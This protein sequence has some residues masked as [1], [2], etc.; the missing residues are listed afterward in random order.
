MN[1]REQLRNILP[2]ILPDDPEEAI[3]GTELIR[4]VRL[5]LGDDY[6]D[7]TLRYHF[8]ILSYD[9]TSPIAK[10]D[11]GQGY[12]QRLS[13]PHLANGT[14]RF[15]F[16]GEVEGDVLQSRFLRLLTIYERLCL[17]RSHFPFRL[18]GRVDT[19][20]D[21]RGFWDI[22][23]LVTAEWDLETGADEI[24]RF[25]S[26]M[27][28]LRRHLGGP[29]VGLSGVQLKIGL[30][31]DNYTAEFFQALSATRWTL[32]SELVIAEPLND[33][34]LVDALRSL[35]NQFG[36]GISSLGINSAQ[37]DDLPSAADLRAMSA[38]EFE[39]VQ[40]KLR[41]QKITVPAPRQRIDW[42]SLSALR[43]KH[44]CVSD[45]VRWLSECL[46]QRKPEWK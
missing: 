11:Q 31:L 28:D 17:L 32:Q 12:Y 39:I 37:L 27:L 33:E 30:T 3:K 29:E 25:D 9:S 7:A 2:D 10:V 16:G 42:T 26:G 38:A 18:N 24:T 40:G 43:K 22:P 36:V 6:S 21:E 14:G 19:P 20:L 8:S 15:L 4:L 23:D 5:R 13:K 34:A 41:I 35:G 46:H 44:E 45:L 1:L